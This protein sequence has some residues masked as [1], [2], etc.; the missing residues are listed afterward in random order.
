MGK[1]KLVKAFIKEC[2]ENP[3]M[4]VDEFYDKYKI[5]KALRTDFGTAALV[6]QAGEVDNE[7]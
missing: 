6:K 7:M 4:T 2:K 5:P 3:L 1:S